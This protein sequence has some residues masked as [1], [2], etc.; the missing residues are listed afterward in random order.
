VFDRHTSAK[1]FHIAAPGR[2]LARLT[3]LIQATRIHMVAVHRNHVSGGLVTKLAAKDRATA[4]SVVRL[5]GAVAHEGA[6]V[7]GAGE[8]GSG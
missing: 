7:S 3:P 5:V 8:R 2:A 1:A 6:Y 4:G